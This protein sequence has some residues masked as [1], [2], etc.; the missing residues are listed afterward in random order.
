MS[1]QANDIGFIAEVARGSSQF[2]ATG[3]GA[4][5]ETLSATGNI[6]IKS[7]ALHLSAAGGT[8]ENFVAAVDSDSGAAYDVTLLSQDMETASDVYDNEERC[9]AAGDDIDFT[10]TNTNG[11]TWGLTV[12][13]AEV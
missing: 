6:V 10:Y 1:S 7:I 3:S 5:T 13:Y 8:A 11:R 12:Q 9:I 2:R 4:M